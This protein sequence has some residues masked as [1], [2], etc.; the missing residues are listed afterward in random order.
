MKI[1]L[2]LNINK[3]YFIRS[4]RNLI[5]M[6]ILR[7]SNV[8]KNVTGQKLLKLVKNY[9]EAKTESESNEE[10]EA[11]ELLTIFIGLFE[12]EKAER[13]LI[14]LYNKKTRK[15]K[16]NMYNE[17]E[18]IMDREEK[19]MMNKKYFEYRSEIIKNDFMKARKCLGNV[20][21]SIYNIYL[22]N[23]LINEE[24]NYEI[25]E[26]DTP[27][28]KQGKKFLETIERSY[29]STA[30][31]GPVARDILRL[32]IEFLEI[33]EEEG[34][35]ANILYILYRSIEST[36]GELTPD[37]FYREKCLADIVFYRKWLKELWLLMIDKL[38]SEEKERLNAKLIEFNYEVKMEDL[39]GEGLKEDLIGMKCINYMIT[40]YV[41]MN[42][43][44]SNE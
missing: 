8:T 39:Y 15:E 9:L 7:Y 21:A 16:I 24:C 34:R 36:R 26:R 33:F 20:M 28:I 30:A 40:I 11:K 1:I 12:K 29:I 35:R 27:E 6:S 42:R 32:V 19:I 4:N 37:N 14:I 17:L 13:I 5:Y 3:E 31:L 10:K 41:I 44:N 38:T 23:N 43:I 25:K 22:K 2:G 18:E